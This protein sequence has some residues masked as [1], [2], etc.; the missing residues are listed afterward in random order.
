MRK[1][2]I[3]MI[4]C[5]LMGSINVFAGENSLLNSE[6]GII[7][8]S[9]VKPIPDTSVY[10][11]ET[12]A[13]FE[14]SAFVG[15]SVM[16]GFQRYCQTKGSG[17]LSDPLFLTSGSFSLWEAVSPVSSGSLHPIYQ[18][19]SMLVEDAVAK[20]GTEKVFI[21]L[22]TNDI[23]W[24]TIDETVQNYND[25]IFRIHTKA[26]NAKVYVIGLTYMYGPSQKTNLNNANMRT[27][28]DTMCQYCEKYDY[29]EFIN[30]GDRL[31]DDDGNLKKEYTSDDYV[32][33]ST[34]GYDVWVKV[35]RAYAKYFTETEQN[36][37]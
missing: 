6:G 34:E 28:N 19:Q 36:A 10:D 4:I 1:T 30:I 15:D 33:I 13:F 22:G 20:S 7:E 18:G 31:I 8:A 17:F 5:M 12:D 29:M 21:Q 14:K 9:Y 11:A 25:L 16:L 37:E 35:L 24:K 26:P 23:G 27:F 2:A 3:L 32:H